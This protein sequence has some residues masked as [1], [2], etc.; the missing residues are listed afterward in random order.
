MAGVHALTESFCRP[1]EWSETELLTRLLD[2]DESAWAEFVRRYR[3]LI[4]SCVLRVTDKVRT[5]A[6]A[7]DVDDIYAEVLLGLLRDDMR[8]LRLYDPARGTKLSSWIGLIAINSAYDYL[9]GVARRTQVDPLD[10]SD[11]A[12]EPYA[13]SPLDILVE[14]ER[15]THLNEVLSAFSEKDRTFMEL[16]YARGLDPVAVAQHMDISLKTV[17]SKKHKIRE[18]LRRHIRTDVHGSAIHDLAA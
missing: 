11:E 5:E 15:W 7:L 6:G 18:H 14:K 10:D 2:R 1:S 3:R 4:Y 13:Q 8:K 17:Y 9:R 16:Y 12:I